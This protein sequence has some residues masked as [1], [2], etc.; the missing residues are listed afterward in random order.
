MKKAFTIIEIL[1]VVGIISILAV[2]LLVLVNPAEAQRRTRDTKRLKDVQF[3]ESVVKQYLDDGGTG[4]IDNSVCTATN[5]CYSRYNAAIGTDDTTPC[6][7][8]NYNWIGEG[9]IDLCNYARAIPVDPSNVDNATCVDDSETNDVST[10]CY[11]HYALVVNGNNYEINA[12]QESTV[13]ID[14]VTG[15]GGNSDESYEVFTQGSNNLMSDEILRSG[16][17]I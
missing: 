3:I 13:N 10:D 5:V 7:A 2:A 4:F 15:D 1:I 6:A 17:G 14:T 8:A 12:R 9:D 11:L 16:T